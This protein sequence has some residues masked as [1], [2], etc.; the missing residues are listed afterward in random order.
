MNA[1]MLLS[2]FLT[3]HLKIMTQYRANFLTGLISQLAYSLL[4]ATFVGAVLGLEQTLQGWTFW[5]VIF[6]F[7]FGDLAFGLSAIFLFRIFFTFESEY[8]IEGKLDQILIQPLPPLFA[9]VLR[10][11][12]LNHLAVV[13]KGL[14]LMA[15]ASHMLGLTW[16]PAGLARLAILA[17]CGA[18]V[19]GGLY[20]AFVSL[21]FW[22][23]RRS[24]LALPVMSL[25]YITQYPLTIYP[26][27][28][29]FL[30]TFVL[31]LGLATYYPAQVFLEIASP[32]AL[33][34]VRYW[35]LPVLSA[36]VLAVGVGLFHL[37]LRSYISSGT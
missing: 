20:I 28:I 26:S 18:T 6:L 13:L 7:G 24:S 23:R 14:A 27:P 11:I 15:L 3:V 17:V 21:G 25:N 29:Q 10:N 31:P 12:D 2:K 33:V 5:H 4:S 32:D 30:L 34:T 8:I 9:L 35:M 22:L 37:G 1:V 19:Y 36:V 16:Q